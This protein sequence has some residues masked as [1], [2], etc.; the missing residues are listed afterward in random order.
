M[1]LVIITGM[2]GAGKSSALRIFEDKGYYCMDNLPPQL[3]GNFIQLAK[4]STESLNK[5]AI[6]VDIRGQAFFEALLY[7]IKELQ[8]EPGLNVQVLFLDARDVVL[9]RRYKELRRPHPMDKAGNI[10]DGIQRE[11]VVLQAAKSEADYILDTSNFTLGQLKEAIDKIFEN[12]SNRPRM[13][14]TIY[15]FGYKHGILLDADLI[16]DARFLPNPFYQDELKSLTGM[17]QAVQDFLKKSDA[18][19]IFMDKLDDLFAFLIPKFIKEGKRTLTVG[20]GCTGGRHR[21]VAL[22]IQLGKILQNQGWP[23]QVRHRDRVYW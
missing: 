22:A 5:I 8:V 18:Y 7:T 6:G 4:T 21:S 20:M 15:S 19:H 14:I 17:D 11:K 23:V 1:D 13:M 2:S 16:F 10:Y 9:V 12:S 3:I